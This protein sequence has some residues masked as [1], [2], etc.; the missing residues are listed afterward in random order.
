MASTRLRQDYLEYNK[1]KGGI[2]LKPRKENPEVHDFL[3]KMCP[4]NHTIEF[5]FGLITQ[6]YEKN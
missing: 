3:V 6:R 4:N 2:Y 5:L 1:N